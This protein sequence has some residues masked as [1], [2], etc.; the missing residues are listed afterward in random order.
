M[1][2]YIIYIYLYIYI[3][4]VV[5]VCKTKYVLAESSEFRFRKYKKIYDLFLI[6]GQVS[7]ISRNINN[8]FWSEMFL[9]FLGVGWEMC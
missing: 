8:F 5:F 3:Y 9:A 4:I 1:Y 7:F 6:L 2:I